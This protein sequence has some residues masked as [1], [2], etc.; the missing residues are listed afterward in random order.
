MT[1]Q[2][3]GS[4]KQPPHGQAA[5]SRYPELSNRAIVWAAVVLIV[6]GASLATVL[7]FVFGNGQ[8]PAQLDAI[9]TGERSSSAQAELPPCG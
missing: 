5:A 1:E 6:I 4:G 2:P 9:K 8:H 3:T 7:L